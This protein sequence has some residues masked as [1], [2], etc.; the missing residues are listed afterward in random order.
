MKLRELIAYCLD[1]VQL[2]TLK[3]RPT[4][5]HETVKS[6][7]HTSY[8]VNFRGFFLRAPDSKPI[9]PNSGSRNRPPEFQVIADFRDVEE[10]LL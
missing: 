6:A 8:L 10:Q 5:D 3:Y 7:N 9:D 4:E 2:S 1:L